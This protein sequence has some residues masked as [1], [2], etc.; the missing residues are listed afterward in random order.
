[1]F[2][3]KDHFKRIESAAFFSK[4]GMNDLYGD[5]FILIENVRKVFVEP[6]DI[7]FK[8]HYNSLEWLPT[9]PSQDDPFYKKQS[10]PKDLIEQ[11][12]EI[13]KCIMNATRN[14]NKNNFIAPPH[15]F[16]VAARGAIS[17][18]FRQYIT[19]QYFGLG[20]KW[21]NIV[22]IYYAGHWPVGYTKENLIII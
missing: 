10:Y 1:M 9:T 3:I 2:D 13:T 20:N 4:M 21:E 16:S 17:F 7:E 15:D 8:G 12:K 5:A 14:I 11:R 22:N 18:A 6:S 19:E